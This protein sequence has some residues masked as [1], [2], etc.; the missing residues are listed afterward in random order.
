[1]IFVT[2]MNQRIYEAYGQRFLD[3]FE[4]F[5]EENITLINVFEGQ[6]PENLLK[7]YS[8]ITTVHFNCPKHQKFVR[9]FGNFYQA[10]GFKMAHKINSQT[11]KY[12][13]QINLDYKYDAIRFSFKV[14]VINYALSLI[15]DSDYLVWTDADLR[16]LRKFNDKDLLEFMPEQNQ[17]MSYLGRIFRLRPTDEPYSECGFLGFNTQHEDFLNFISRMIEVY[18]TGEIF[19]M[20]QWHDS[21]VWDRVREEFEGKGV[22]FKNLSGEFINTHHPFVNTNLGKYFDHLKGPKRKAQGH[23]DKT[24]DY[25]KKN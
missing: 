14:F 17:L 20:L 1:M 24:I 2:S 3:E 12:D 7:K 6:P 21:W 19:T 25:V 4:Q 13:F 9:Y 11:N 5:V 23:S 10:R 22:L 8:K 15:K 18:S 16:C